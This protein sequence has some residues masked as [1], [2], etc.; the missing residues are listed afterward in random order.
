M[1]DS[2]CWINW[3]AYQRG[4]AHDQN[5]ADQPGVVKTS[6]TSQPVTNHGGQAKKLDHDGDRDQGASLAIKHFA[7]F[8]GLGVAM[9]TGW[10]YRFGGAGSVRQMGAVHVE[11]SLNYQKTSWIPIRFPRYIFQNRWLPGTLSFIFND[12]PFSESMIGFRFRE[13][14]QA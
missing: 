1:S 13:T 4:D 10:E 14:L 2:R 6:L 5:S 3:H 7:A 8:I 9:A 12:Q 11:R